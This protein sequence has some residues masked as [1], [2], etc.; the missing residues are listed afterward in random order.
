MRRSHN[1]T[2]FE[3]DW[4]YPKKKTY[5]YRERDEEKRQ[6]FVKKLATVEPSLIVYADEAGMDQRD[7]YGYGYSLGCLLCK[8]NT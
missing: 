8:K 3:E 5:G 4:I 7:D 6:E 2:C 1:I